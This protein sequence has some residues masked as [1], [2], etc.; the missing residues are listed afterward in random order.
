[1][2]A[3]V[4]LCSL[5]WEGYTT[6]DADQLHQMPE[7]VSGTTQLSLPFASAIVDVN[8]EA[9]ESPSTP[10]FDQY[11]IDWILVIEMETA[12]LLKSPHLLSRADYDAF[13]ATQGATSTR[14]RSLLQGGNQ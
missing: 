2:N 5:N 9:L 12:I 11:H 13:V 8:P 3:E 14:L 10:C 7:N 1:M 4:P 6:P